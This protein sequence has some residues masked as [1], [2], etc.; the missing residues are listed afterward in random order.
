[1]T[2]FLKC[3][4]V[5][6]PLETILVILNKLGYLERLVK[7]AKKCKDE[8]VQHVV[9]VPIIATPLVIKRVCINKTIGAKLCT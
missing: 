4:I 5:L 1:L 9:Q 7:L 3:K 6:P 2:H 8:E